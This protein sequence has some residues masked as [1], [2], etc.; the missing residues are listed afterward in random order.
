[1]LNQL[2]SILQAGY[3]VIGISS[4]GPEVSVIEAAGFRHIPVPMTRN[5]TPLADL[6]SLFRLYRV[7]HR[8]RFDIVHTHNPKP[9][10]FCGVAL[11]LRVMAS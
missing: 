2:R 6:L 11:E 3:K 7:M 8:E 1:L 5:L 9:G 4:P 10:F